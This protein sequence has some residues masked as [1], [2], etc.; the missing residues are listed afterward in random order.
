M[1]PPAVAAVISAARCCC[2]PLLAVLADEPS[3]AAA[4]VSV[5]SVISRESRADDARPAVPGGRGGV[6][7]ESCHNVL[8]A[9]AGLWGSSVDGHGLRQRAHTACF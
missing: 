7:C 1:A 6:T 5:R 4:G 9:L 3:W 8:D 2:G